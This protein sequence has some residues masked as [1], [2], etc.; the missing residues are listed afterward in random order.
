[1]TI[2]DLKNK[3]TNLSRN[4]IS[5]DIY[6]TIKACIL[7]GTIMQGEHLK[8]ME[9]AKQFNT[10]QAPV[11]EAFKKLQQERLLKT[12]PFKGTFIEEI[13]DEEIPEIYQLRSVLETISLKWFISKM[14]E[15]NIQELKLI[16]K[17]MKDAS[18]NDDLTLL[19]EKDI[20][21]HKY[22]CKVSDSKNLY[23]MWS[24]I[25]GKSRLVIAKMDII[26]KK[27]KDVKK[28]VKLHQQILEAIEK[29]DVMLAIERYNIH[30]KFVFREI[31]K[32]DTIDANLKKILGKYITE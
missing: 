31:V 25:N 6:E 9:I 26:Y 13:S 29:K 30:T 3:L 7:D 18:L 8:E 19:V 27:H 2:S 4:L 28:I 23:P 5:D 11:R 20:A 16:I 32:E 21:F 22:I 17:D 14:T 12:I 24:I 15:E 1:M 10:S